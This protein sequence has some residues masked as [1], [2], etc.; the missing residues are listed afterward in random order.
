MRAAASRLVAELRRRVDVLGGP[1]VS[2]I[3]LLVF[4]AAAWVS[5]VVP[6]TEERDLLQLES[7]KLERH[8]RGEASAAARAPSAPAQLA[9]FYAF[10]PGAASTPDWLA[11]IHAAAVAKGLTLASGEYKVGKTGSPRLA[12]YQITLPVQ[13][14]YPQIRGFIGA[15]LAE[16][17]AAVI[18]EVSLKR[19]SVESERLD[20]RIRI[21]LYM[22]APRG[23]ESG[24]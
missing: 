2:G 16:V 22:A 1:G 18:E 10:F 20:A 11:R 3:A 7:D 13:G 24:A 9:T 15:V 14:T 5:G 21:A 4:S 8:H 23:A 6:A 12:R 17:P 19:E